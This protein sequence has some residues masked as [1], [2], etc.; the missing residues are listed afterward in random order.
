[1]TPSSFR[2]SAVRLGRTRS[3]ISFSRKT[4]S[5]RSRPRLR[6]QPPRSVSVSEHITAG[7]VWRGPGDRWGS[8]RVECAIAPSK[9]QTLFTETR[10]S[11]RQ[12]WPPKHRRAV[13]TLWPNKSFAI[14]SIKRTVFHQGPAQSPRDFNSRPAST[15]VSRCKPLRVGGAYHADISH[16]HPRWR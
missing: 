1:V 9:S 10:P 13:P 16:L 2:S 5:Y 12:N 8:E 15:T 3:F 14:R 7:A 6:S 11:R 4:A